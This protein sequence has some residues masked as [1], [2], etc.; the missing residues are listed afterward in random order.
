[1]RSCTTCAQ[2]KHPIYL[3]AVEMGTL[4]QS[5]STFFCLWGHENYFPKGESAE[6]KL[7]R[8]RDSLRQNEAWY[9]QRLKI[10]SAE[11][12]AAERRASAARGQITKLKKRVAGGA[13]PC[14]NRT[15]ENL[16][17]HMQTKHAGFVAEEVAPEGVVIQ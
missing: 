2:C 4:R 8:E 3:T 13:C 7:R 1:M 6:D 10:E 5:S 15:F 12:Q 14:C 16:A 11:R 9:E 17:R